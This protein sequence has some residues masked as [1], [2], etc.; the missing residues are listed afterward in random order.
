M[1]IVDERTAPID[2][3]LGALEIRLIEAVDGRLAAA[4]GQFGGTDG[5]IKTFGERLFRCRRPARR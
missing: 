3:R 2:G 5:T 4:S 1:A